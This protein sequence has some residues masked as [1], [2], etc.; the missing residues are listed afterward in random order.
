MLTEDVIRFFGA[1]SPFQFLDEEQLR[2]VARD[3]SMEFYPS[4][5]VILKQNGPP[6]DA[7][8][9]IKKGAVKVIMEGDEG[10]EIVTE[11]KGEGDNFGFLSMIGRDRQRTTVKAVEDTLC[12]TLKKERVQRLLE[13]SPS[14]AEYFMAYLSRYID[15]TFQEMRR[16]NPLNGTSDRLLFTTPVREIALPLITAP[17]STT[18]QEAAQLMVKHKISSLV[19]LNENNIPAGIVTDRDLRE[20]VVAKGRSVSDPVKNVSNLSL[21]R[22]EAKGSCFEALMKMIQYNIHHVL[23][24]DEGRLTGIV[25]NHDLMLLQGTSPVSFAKDIL[26]QE[27]I[28][29]LVPLTKK[30]FNVIAL[31]LKEETRFSNL[32]NIVSEIYDRLFRKVLELAEKK[33]GPPPLPYCWVVIGSEGRR[34]QIFKSDQ[35]NVLIYSDPSTPGEE[36]DA[37]SYFSVFAEW[38]RESLLILGIPPC[39]E[40]FMAANPRWCQPFRVWK[41]LFEGWIMNPTEE[42]TPKFINFFD[43]RPLYG[44]YMLFQGVKDQIGPWINEEGDQ[45]LRTLTMLAL[46][47]PPPAGFVGNKVFEKDGTSALKLDL[48]RRGILPLVDLIRLFSL[49][50][51]LSET[52]TLARI[53]GVKIKESEIAKIEGELTH[54]FDYMM[55]LLIHHQYQQIRFGLRPDSML[56]PNQL[57]S[58]DRKTLREAFQLI[59]RVQN[60]ARQVFLSEPS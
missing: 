54:A 45:F 51:G 53:A 17:A 18:I 19:I 55:L 3:V 47:T 26:V 9:I 12:Y 15:R 8:R 60:L 5:T 57:S 49:K 43:A 50:H 27:S 25:T 22:A 41:N 29:G 56:E 14:F 31:L 44:K 20:K 59:A 38:I 35:D 28:E 7:L 42:E 6:S 1:V 13:S 33:L 46:R 4:N 16:R 21:I 24:V 58:I 36:I 23:V 37:A 40:G 30:I 2:K 39:K 32:S 48:K 34:E 52:S 10:E 11:Y